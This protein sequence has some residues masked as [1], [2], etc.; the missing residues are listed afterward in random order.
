[1]NE[2][3]FRDVG[4]CVLLT[5]YIEF[6]LSVIL[7]LERD[8]KAHGEKDV[9]AFMD[10]LADIRSSS[11]I[12]TLEKQLRDIGV[13]DDVLTDLPDVSKRRN[14]I[15]HRLVHDPSFLRAL[16][17]PTAKAVFDADLRLFALCGNRLEQYFRARA[18]ALGV[19][20]IESRVAADEQIFAFGE[21]VLSRIQSRRDKK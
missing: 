8:K 13:P 18:K 16:G 17:D 15:A 19:P 4:E 21:G 1:M 6:W 7:M 3:L 10:T 11:Y 2:K 20:V 14:H 9:Y 5:Q 12:S